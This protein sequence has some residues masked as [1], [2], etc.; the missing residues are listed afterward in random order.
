MFPFISDLKQPCEICKA[1]L[2]ILFDGCEV[3]ALEGEMIWKRTWG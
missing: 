1:A 3:K 2:I